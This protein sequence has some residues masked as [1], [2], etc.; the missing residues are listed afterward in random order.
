MFLLLLLQDPQGSRRIHGRCLPP[1]RAAL[2][3]PPR[4]YSLVANNKAVARE[5][6]SPDPQLAW[7]RAQPP[8]PGALVFL[9][10]LSQLRAS[11]LSAAITVRTVLNPP[12]S[13]RWY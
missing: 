12:L 13:L 5:T 2:L 8:R 11:L 6:L 1:P 10:L 3:G 9:P 4:D 7:L